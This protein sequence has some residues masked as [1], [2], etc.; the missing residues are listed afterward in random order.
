MLQGY[1]CMMFYTRNPT[2]PN[3]QPAGPPGFWE[4]LGRGSI[5]GKYNRCGTELRWDRRVNVK[6]RRVLG[7]GP[8]WRGRRSITEHLG[9]QA[10]AWDRSPLGTFDLLTQISLIVDRLAA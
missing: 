1:F 9:E 6:V 2:V 3:L 7:R 5:P 8:D 10:N 4:M